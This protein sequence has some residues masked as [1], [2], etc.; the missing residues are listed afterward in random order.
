[1]P[2]VQA[3]AGQPEPG[4]GSVAG[5]GTPAES[6]PGGE[7]AESSQTANKLGPTPVQDVRLLQ[8][9]LNQLCQSPE[10]IDL[11]TGKPKEPLVK[12]YGWVD[13]G[14]TASTSGS[15]PLAVEP[16]PNRFGNEF[17]LNQF[18]LTI[19]KPLNPKELSWGFLIQPYAGA[20]AALLNPI[21]GAVVENPDQRFGF[22]FRNLYLQAHLPILTEGGIDVEVGQHY[23]LIGYQSAMAP[24]RT[25]YS[26]DYQWFYGEAG[27]FTGFIVTTHVNK[28]L[29][30]VNA[31]SLGY[32]TFF[33]SL[34]VAPTYMG[35]VDYWL[36]EEKKT[37]VS[38]GVVTGPESPQSWDNTTLVDVTVT[39]NWDKRLTQVVQFGAGYSKTG[40][41]VPGLQRYYG[42]Y[43]M[44]LYHLTPKLDVNFRAEWYDDVDGRNYP[45]GTG[46][47]NNYEEVTLGI[48]YHPTKW[49]QIRP[50]LRADFANN[51]PAFGP[52]NGTMS[53]SQFTPAIEC[54]L[55]F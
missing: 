10:Q 22:D 54:L 16:R 31:M 11:A 17:S 3:P 51:T 39:H 6:R 32:I 37:L 42:L 50:E 41:F 1:M 20:D 33:T 23:P 26:N 18:A 2:L 36:Q 21:R 40:I 12:I 14:Y 47:R 19:E 53:R 25:F 34:S 45:G 27:S 29:D 13:T 8:N 4:S 5:T 28:Q 35:R 9:L 52:V 24:Y 30:I 55:K 43:N 44:F 46:F 49:L 38:L 15:G 48:D 7:A